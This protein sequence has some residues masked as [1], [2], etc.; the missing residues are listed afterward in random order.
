MAPKYLMKS[1]LKRSSRRHCSWWLHPM[2]LSKLV[3]QL[4]QFKFLSTLE[5]F[6]FSQI[7]S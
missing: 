2:Q 1:I 3:S 5:S 4:A 6:Y 7:F